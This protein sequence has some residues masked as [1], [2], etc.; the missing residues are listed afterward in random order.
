MLSGTENL[1]GHFGNMADMAN[2]IP[3]VK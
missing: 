3:K 1:N 2:K